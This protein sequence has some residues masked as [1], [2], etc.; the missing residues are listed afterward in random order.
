MNKI[1]L[2]APLTYTQVYELN[3]RAKTEKIIIVFEN[4]K[5]LKKELLASLSDNITIS[6]TGGLTPKKTKFNNEHYQAR[7]YYTKK[8]LIAIIEKFEIIERKINPL[9]TDE[10]KM[11]FVYQKLCVYLNYKEE[12]FNGK[13]SSRNLLGLLTGNSVCAGCAM[14][15]KE[16]MDRLGIKCYYQNMQRHHGWNVVEINGKYYGLDLTWDIGAKKN[17]T[18]GFQY[19]CRED[20]KQFYSNQH[21]DLSWESEETEYNLES[22]PIEKLQKMCNKINEA[23]ITYTKTEYS[24]GQETCKVMGKTIVIKNNVPYCLENPS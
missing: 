5:G 10:E 16:A 17:N 7:T 18:C 23:K 1:Y 3:Q 15:F 12:F 6:I 4:T 19:F 8:E 13:E 2:K 21:H 14:I 11:M 20:K 22:I 9:W 24:E